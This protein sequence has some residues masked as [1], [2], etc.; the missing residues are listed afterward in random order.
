MTGDNSGLHSCSWLRDL[1][2]SPPVKGVLRLSV[3]AAV[4]PESYASVPGSA[5]RVWQRVS[6]GVGEGHGVTCPHGPGPEA[7]PGAGGSGGE[8]QFCFKSSSVP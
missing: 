5:R 8:R 4:S 2:G 7:D 1:M 3:A 6:T